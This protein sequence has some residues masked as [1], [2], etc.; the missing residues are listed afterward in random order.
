MRV[1]LHYNPEDG[2][3]YFT[4]SG[5]FNAFHNNQA[6]GETTQEDF[7]GQITRQVNSVLREFW[8]QIPKSAC[9]K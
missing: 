8:L 9:E 5:K 7:N 2:E 4:L 6:D 1:A 3:M